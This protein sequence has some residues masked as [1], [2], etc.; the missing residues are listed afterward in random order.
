MSVS[1]VRLK[2]GPQLT[3]QHVAK[4]SQH[5]HCLSLFKGRT[6]LYV[7]WHGIDINESCLVIV[8]TLH[9]EPAMSQQ[10]KA[11]KLRGCMA[12]AG[13]AECIPAIQGTV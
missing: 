11:A 8:S 9:I 13:C 2:H 12:A 4:K 3:R 1:E 10:V 5:L 7:I 6:L